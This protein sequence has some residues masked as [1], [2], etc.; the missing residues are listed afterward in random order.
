MR[1][2]DRIE[3]AL[4]E[5]PVWEPPAQF[6]KRVAMAAQRER[7]LVTERPR[8]VFWIGAAFQGAA[9]ALVA[10]V[11]SS[12]ISSAATSAALTLGTVLERYARSLS[13]FSL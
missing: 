6:A 13:T 3:K 1:L 8:G 7:S 5:L 11:G 2:D 4:S 10:Y 9:V 12:A